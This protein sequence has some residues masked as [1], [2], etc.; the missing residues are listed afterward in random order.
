MPTFT[1]KL[2]TSPNPCIGRK[3]YSGRYL[4]RLHH[5]NVSL[6]VGLP[7]IGKTTLLFHLAQLAREKM[8]LETSVYLPLFP[9]EGISSVLARTEARILG[10]AGQ[11]SES[12]ADAYRRLTDLLDGHKTL[13]ILDNLH[14]F[15]HDDLVALL[16]TVSAYPGGYRIVAG[17]N[18]EPD[19]SAMERSLLH[20]ELLKQ[21]HPD[22]VKEILESRGVDGELQD[23]LQRDAVRGGASAHPLTLHFVI[24]LSRSSG[25]L[26]DDEF[27]MGLSARSQKTFQKVWETLNNAVTETQHRVMVTLAH[28]GLP[29]EVEFARSI[30]GKD[31]D[32]LLRVRF[33]EEHDGSV[34]L[35]RTVRKLLKSRLSLSSATHVAALRSIFG[36]GRLSSVSRWVFS[37]QE[38]SWRTLETPNLHSIPSLLDGKRCETLDFRKPT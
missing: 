14:C 3:D 26:P 16:R 18:F 23:T 25:R 35:A 13:L 8:D 20:V 10:R 15:R 32:E 30:L 22:E 19:L 11:S 38:S 7:G 2:P 34:G 9:G 21:L 36:I 1:P 28:I 17:S 6:F 4:A 24:S 33:I 31:V 37:A 5:Y 12:Q 29:I 27:L